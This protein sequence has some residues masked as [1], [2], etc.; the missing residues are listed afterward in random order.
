MRA[1]NDPL[2]DFAM[3]RERIRRDFIASLPQRVDAI[4]AGWREISGA[5]WS[6]SGVKDLHRAAHTL[7]GSGKTF[8]CLAVSEAAHAIEAILKTLLAAHRPPQ[9]DECAAVE[10]ALLSLDQA[11]RAA[12]DAPRPQ[13]TKP[14]P[15]HSTD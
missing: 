2:A 6:E 4:Q 15:L 5:N 13:E 12:V 9:A 3:R 11:M 7:N 14:P 10:S 8:G 1:M